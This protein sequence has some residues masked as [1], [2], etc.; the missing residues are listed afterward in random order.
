MSG[1]RLQNSE[2]KLG[3]VIL[4]FVVAMVIA[5]VV[6]NAAGRK[7]GCEAEDKTARGLECVEEGK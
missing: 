7:D 5:F 2:P 6:A 1:V 3:G 4:T